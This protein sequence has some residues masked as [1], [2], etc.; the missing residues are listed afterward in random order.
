MDEKRDVWEGGM[1]AAF[2]AAG[3]RETGE[4][5]LDT[6]E[7]LSGTRARLLLHD[8]ES[9]TA[10]VIRVGPQVVADDSRYQMVGE[11]ARGGVGVIYKAR[12]K[13]LGRDIALKVL[14]DIHADRADVLERFVEEAQ[15]GGQ[16]QH[17]GIV[18]VYGLGLQLDGRPYFAMKLIKGRTLG[19]RLKERS[20]PAV[21]R[22]RF[23]QIFEQT[24]QT[25][26]YVHARGVIHRDLKPAN[27]LVGNFGEVQVIDWGF[28]KVLGRAEPAPADDDIRTRIATVRSGS[29]GSDS[30]VGSVMGTPA[31]MPPEQALGHIDELDEQTDVF[32]LG[33]ILC[34]ILTGAPAYT[35][36]S[37]DLLVLASQ[38]RL[39]DAYSRLANCGADA[40]IVSIC[41]KAL[42]PLRDQRFADG[43]ELAGEISSYLT[44][45]EERARQA[46]VDAI[47]EQG[48]LEDERA[49]A[50]W[51]RRAKYRV[52][53]LAAVVLLA[54]LL[55]GG[56]WFQENAREQARV[57]DARLP[58]EDSM[59]DATMLAGRAH[60]DEALAV[61]HK[62]AALAADPDMTR[63]AAALVA[64][65]E[66]KKRAAE[67]EASQKANDAALLR[68]LEDLRLIWF[69]DDKPK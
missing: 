3:G 59:Q 61:A 67:V 12:D 32:A 17:P 54:V 28:G 11:I 33:A 27:I 22:R 53:T 56:L 35:G 10:P 36:S 31:Y 69:E 45:A 5:V 37:K 43:G 58:F 50:R 34:E 40:A 46:E 4:S 16:L 63:G 30:L 44:A 26:A 39:D 68:A 66:R 6:I 51:E 23:L 64:E 19:A 57:A 65:I 13:D 20:D 41:K 14:R 42:A 25:M 47:A 62:A 60:W 21:D 1:R 2:S 38:A 55:G 52:R 49:R 15:I 18:P 9:D 48:R 8:D 24:C 7:R 29:E